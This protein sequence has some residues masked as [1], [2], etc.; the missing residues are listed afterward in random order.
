M[1]GPTPMPRLRSCPAVASAPGLS[2]SF[3]CT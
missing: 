1:A 3:T 2:G